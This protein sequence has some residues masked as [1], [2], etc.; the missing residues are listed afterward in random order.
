[1][2]SNGSEKVLETTLN[3][4]CANAPPQD[5]RTLDSFAWFES[6]YDYSRPRTITSGSKSSPNS[7]NEDDNE[8]PPLGPDGDLVSAMISTAVVPR[9]C[10]VVQGGAFDPYSEKHVRRMVD[11]AEQVEASVGREKYEASVM[12]TAMKIVNHLL[13][14]FSPC[15]CSSNP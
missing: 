11:L 4:V 6:L 1:M 3:E 8:D 9:L 14:P 2:G 5:P 15:R 13:T 12:V 7:G 10:K